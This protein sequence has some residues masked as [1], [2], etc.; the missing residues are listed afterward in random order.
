ML[1][2]FFSKCR[3]YFPDGG[4]DIIQIFFFQQGWRFASQNCSSQACSVT[5]HRP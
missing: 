2:A 3:N 1:A 4:S 5:G